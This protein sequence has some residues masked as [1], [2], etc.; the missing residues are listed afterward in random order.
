MVISD[1]AFILLSPLV[2][3]FFGTQTDNCIVEEVKWNEQQGNN[4]WKCFLYYVKKDK[5]IALHCTI[6]IIIFAISISLHLNLPVLS[7]EQSSNFGF[8]QFIILPWTFKKNMFQVEAV[9]WDVWV[10][11]FTHHE[12]SSQLL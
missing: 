3:A 1:L 9:L 8:P 5:T 7:P 10:V 4:I 12:H 6:N 2:I 11:I